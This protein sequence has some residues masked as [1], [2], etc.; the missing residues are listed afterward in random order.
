MQ[1]AYDT[2]S[3]SAHKDIEC[4]TCHRAS[5]ADENRYLLTMLIKR[6][7]EIPARHGRVIV[8]RSVCLECHWDG[9]PKIAKVNASAG[10]NQHAFIQNIQ[11]TT[12]HAQQVHRFMPDS[13]V[14]ANCH[15]ETVKARGMEN[16]DCQ[17]CHH[18]KAEPAGSKSL[19][20]MPAR[21]TCLGCHQPA[22]PALFPSGAPMTFQCSTCHQPHRQPLPTAKDCLKCH[23]AV[24]RVGRHRVHMTEAGLTCGDCHRPHAWKISGLRAL[25]RLSA[26][27]VFHRGDTGGRSVDGPR[28]GAGLA[29]G[30]GPQIPIAFS[31]G[32]R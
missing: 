26:A 2:W 24:A 20:L 12:C 10:H 30:D 8:P 5:I 31:A 27:R 9:D 13:R 3:H 23:A 11:C 21:E 14:C 18:W 25:P 1:A 22:R 32:G 19:G 17:L 29:I 4:H 16:H 7:K 6:P 15:A 28:H